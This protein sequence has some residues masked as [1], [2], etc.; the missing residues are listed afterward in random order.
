MTD[1]KDVLVALDA[2]RDSCVH[3]A[4]GWCTPDVATAVKRE[5]DTINDFLRPLLVPVEE[6]VPAT[7]K[8]K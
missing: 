1:P 7:K 6:P 5:Y 3:L 2:L 8:G 4:N